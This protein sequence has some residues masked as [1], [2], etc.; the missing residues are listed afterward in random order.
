MPPLSTRRMTARKLTVASTA[1][2]LLVTAGGLITP[3]AAQTQVPYAE[4]MRV[5]MNVLPTASTYPTTILAGRE[6]VIWVMPFAGAETAEAW[7]SQ[8]DTSRFLP[9]APARWLAKPKT[10]KASPR[11]GRAAVSWYSVGMDCGRDI[12]PVCTVSYY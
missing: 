4:S 9:V 10:G 3:C 8:L 6:P 7:W 5:D 12:S 2:A 11:L 1:L